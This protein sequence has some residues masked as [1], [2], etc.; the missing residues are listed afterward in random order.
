MLFLGFLLLPFLGSCLSEEVWDPTDP[1][2][3][4]RRQEVKQAWN[5]YLGQAYSWID[6]YGH[7]RYTSKN[8]IV[9]YR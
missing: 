6:R 2:C 3:E 9:K 4:E 5:D 8:Y 1:R 7:G